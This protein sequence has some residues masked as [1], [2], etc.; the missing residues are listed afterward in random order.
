MKNLIQQLEIETF[1]AQREWTVDGIPVLQADISLPC[2]TAPAGRIQRRI[3]RFYQ[4]Q[5]RSYLR[6]CENWLAPKAAA[7]CRQALQTSAPL[8]QYTARLTYHITCNENGIWSLHTDSHEFIG[9]KPLVLRRGDT[10]DLHTGYPLPITSFFPHHAL[11]RKQLLQAAANEIRRQEAAGV[12]CY[13]TAWPQKLKRSFNRNNFFVTPELLCFFWQMYAIAPAAEG[14]PTFSI[15]LDGGICLPPR[16]KAE[17]GAR[18]T[19]DTVTF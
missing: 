1:S 14:I 17:S 9:G 12:S 11:V 3:E 5:S 15:P 16:E 6:Y 7:D 10:W 19:P 4:L 8:P 2:P 18:R 13:D